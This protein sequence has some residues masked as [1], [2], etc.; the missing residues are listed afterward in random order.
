MTE[1][2]VETCFTD[3]KVLSLSLNSWLACYYQGTFNNL[4]SCS[5]ASC[6]HNECW[7]SGLATLHAIPYISKNQGVGT[8]C[9][10]G[11]LTT[12]DCL[13]RLHLKQ[14]AYIGYHS[15][16]LFYFSSFCSFRWVSGCLK[17]RVTNL[18]CLNCTT[19][20][21]LCQSV[22]ARTQPCN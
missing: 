2:S 9:Y 8:K 5:L 12:I 4:K 18:G 7:N 14:W 16:N 13:S 22:S 21:C 20:S 11:I 15:L 19:V 10:M 6:L 1:V 17:A 3:S